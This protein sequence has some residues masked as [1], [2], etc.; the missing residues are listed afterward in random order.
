M[1]VQSITPILNVSSVPAS[2]RWFERLGWH[3]GFTWN[4]GGLIAHVALENRQGPA[5][6]GSVCANAPGAGDAPQIFLCQDGQGHRDPETKPD[7]QR[8]DYGGVWMSWWVDDVD[9]SHAECVR[10]GVEVVNAPAN[11][12]WGVREFLLRHP[13]GH[14]VRVSGFVKS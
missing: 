6:F 5:T 7:P 4:A 9:A 3:R 8:D 2:I 14:M 13:D 12:R 10:A 1:R 11:E